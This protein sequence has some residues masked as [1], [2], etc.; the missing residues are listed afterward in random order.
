MSTR[1]KFGVSITFKCDEA[2]SLA[3][4]ELVRMREQQAGLPMGT[5][6]RGFVIRALVEEARTDMLATESPIGRARE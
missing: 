5:L 4:E 3:L 2:F 6:T 1:G